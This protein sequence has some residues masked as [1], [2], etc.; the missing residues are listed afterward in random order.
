MIDLDEFRATMGVGNLYPDETLQQVA[1][2][3]EI[4]INGMLDYSRASII[5]AQVSSNVAHFDT[6]DTHP[7]YIG[8]VLTVSGTDA[9]F[10]GSRTVTDV[11][12]M[13]F[14]CAL[15]NANTEAIKY[16][17]YGQALLASQS[18]IYDSLAPVR[19]AALAVAIEI[20][21]QRTAPGG[22]VQAVDFTPTPHRLGRALLNRVHGLLAP[23]MDLGGFVG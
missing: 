12:A 10:N 18:Q 21:Q 5:G 19:E 3:A 1:D 16:K 11:G 20:F 2:A 22:Q 23:Y 8:A 15:T 13:W 4:L 17:P 9:V 7:F 14:K 6:A